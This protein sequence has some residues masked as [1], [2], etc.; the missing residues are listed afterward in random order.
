MQHV[1]ASLVCCEPR[2][3]DGHPSERAH[4]NVTIGLSAPRAS[5]VFQLDHFTGCFLDEGFDH[6]L[7][8][9]PIGPR[10]GVISVTVQ[11]VIGFDDRRSASLGSNRMAAHRIHLGNHG[12]AKLRVRLAQF[13]R[14]PQPC[15]PAADDQ[16]VVLVALHPVNLKSPD[17]FG[18]SCVNLHS[19]QN[20]AFSGYSRLLSSLSPYESVPCGDQ[21]RGQQRSVPSWSRERRFVRSPELY[22]SAS[23]AST[24]QNLPP[25]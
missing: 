10:H 14:G 5:P 21:A 4:S 2:P 11:A 7:V 18:A 19:I 17:N 6:V 22:S 13:N 25:T 24:L 20:I 1:K 23:L 12:N 16:N 9:Q 8:A 3:L 15:S